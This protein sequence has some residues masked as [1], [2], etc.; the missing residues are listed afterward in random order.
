MSLGIGVLCILIGMML[1][2][3]IADIVD[4]IVYK[5]VMRRKR[6]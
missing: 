5:K 1:G 4:L 3:L 6:E 2:I